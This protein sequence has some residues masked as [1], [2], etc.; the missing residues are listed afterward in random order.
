MEPPYLVQRKD[1]DGFWVNV[2]E[3]ASWKHAVRTAQIEA[4]ESGALHRAVYGP[5]R[6]GARLFVKQVRQADAS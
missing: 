4:N 5:Q 3:C 2:A 6:E 1:E